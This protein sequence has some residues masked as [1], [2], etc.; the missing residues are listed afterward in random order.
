MP[1]LAPTKH[2]VGKQDTFLPKDSLGCPHVLNEVHPL[3]YHPIIGTLRVTCTLGQSGSGSD[4][5]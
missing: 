5:N 2:A 3:Y 4:G 1:F